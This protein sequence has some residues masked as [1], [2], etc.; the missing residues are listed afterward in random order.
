MEWGNVAELLQAGGGLAQLAHAVRSEHRRRKEDFARRLEAES[1]LTV[2]QIAE[3]IADDLSRILLLERAL[4]IA[5]DAASAEKRRVLARVVADALKNQD[6]PLE[7]ADLLLNTIRDLE[8]YHIALLVKLATPTPGGGALSGTALEGAFSEYELGKALPE[9]QQDLLG[10]VLAGLE[11][12]D[13]IRLQSASSGPERCWAA[14]D[15]GRRFLRYLPPEEQPA[16]A[17]L[18]RAEIAVRWEGPPSPAI[19]IRNLGPGTAK[20]KYFKYPAGILVDPF[21]GPFTLRAGRERSLSAHDRSG[22]TRFHVKVTWQ[23]ET[24]LRE[25]SGKVSSRQRAIGGSSAP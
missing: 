1:Q 9:D 4:A 19:V 3:L 13:L 24:G 23:D 8:A 21:P 6:M 12:Q 5:D 17:L 14:S 15:Y 2:G 7:E 11:R 20:I 10:P 18:L 16:M 22:Q 25:W